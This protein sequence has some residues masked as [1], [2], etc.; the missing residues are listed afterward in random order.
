MAKVILDFKRGLDIVLKL[1]ILIA[2]SKLNVLVSLQVVTINAIALCGRSSLF[3]ILCLLL[4]EFLCGSATLFFTLGPA[5]AEWKLRASFARDLDGV[6][7]PQLKELRSQS[8][9]ITEAWPGKKTLHGEGV[10]NSAQSSVLWIFFLS[11][12]PRPRGKAWLVIKNNVGCI[13]EHSFHVLTG[14][15]SIVVI[16][17]NLSTFLHS[18]G[19][20]SPLPLLLWGCR[21]GFIIQPRDF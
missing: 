10:E 11:I 6:A 4:H 20:N 5:H 16:N 13:S 3:Y 19:T 1:N 8:T 2:T 17:D 14:K 15:L 21:G 7:S 18:L 9:I 12:L